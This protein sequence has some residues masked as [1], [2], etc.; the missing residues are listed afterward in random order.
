MDGASLSK[1]LR[2]L[3]LLFDSAESM[4]VERACFSAR[5]GVVVIDEDVNSGREGGWVESGVIVETR[6]A[7]LA[8]CP[9]E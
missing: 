7:G 5:A 2:R 4:C 9:G 8:G 1:A 3:G 6:G